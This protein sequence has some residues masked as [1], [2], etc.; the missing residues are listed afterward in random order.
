MKAYIEKAER[1]FHHDA[2]DGMGQ[3]LNDKHCN[4]ANEASAL[5][6]PLNMLV[7]SLQISRIAIYITFIHIIQI[8]F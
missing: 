5:K 4:D 8:T 3:G 2:V 7:F 6:K 1:K